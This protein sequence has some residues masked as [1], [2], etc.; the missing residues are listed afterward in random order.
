MF[1]VHLRTDVNPEVLPVKLP[2]KPCEYCGAMIS[3][4]NISAH[5]KRYHDVSSKT[6]NEKFKVNEPKNCKTCGKSFEAVWKMRAHLRNSRKCGGG[7]EMA[8][9]QNC[10]G[11]F[12][13]KYSLKLHA[14]KV[15]KIDRDEVKVKIEK[16][17]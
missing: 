11:I 17:S 5:R 15:C 10:G 6:H 4:R 1:A 13:S 8:K 14:Q 12:R 2:I 3:S 9:C 7:P 16:Y